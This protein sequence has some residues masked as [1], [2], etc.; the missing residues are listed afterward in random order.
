MEDDEM[1]ESRYDDLQ[2]SK[3]EKRRLR[4]EYRSLQ[5]AL[6]DNREAFLKPDNALAE[7]IEKANTLFKDVKSTQEATLDAKF[8][9]AAA[10]LSAQKASKLRLTG[11]VVEPFEVVNRV[12][13]MLGGVP[14]EDR[15]NDEEQHVPRL[16][17]NALKTA[18]AESLKRAPFGPLETEPKARKERKEIQRLKKDKSLLTKPTELKA[19][20]IEKQVNETA[21]MYKFIAKKLQQTGEINFFEFVINPDSFSQ[22]VE[23][24][25]YVAFLVKDGKA[26]III[27][28]EDGQPYIRRTALDEEEEDGGGQSTSSTSSDLSKKQVIFELTHTIWKELIETYDIREPCI[29]TRDPVHVNVDPTSSRCEFHPIQGPKIVYEVSEGGIIKTNASGPSAAAS[30]GKG[31]STSNL[32]PATLTSPQPGSV[33]FAVPQGNQTTSTSADSTDNQLDFESISEYIIPKPVLCNRLVTISTKKYKVMG[34]PVSIEDP[35]YERNA[36][37]FNLCFVFDKDANTTSYEQIVKKMARVLRSLEVESEFLCNAVTKSYILNIMEQLLQDLNTYFECQIPIN[38]ANMINLKLLPVYP[39]PEPVKDWH[40]PVALLNL[41]KATDKYWDM[42]IRRVVPFINGVFYVKKI[43]EVADVELELVRIAIQ[44]LLYFGC[45]KLVDIFK[46]EWISGVSR[47]PG[48]VPTLDSDLPP[49]TFAVVF[50]LF[51][52]FK[53]G[54]TVREWVEENNVLSLNIDIRRLIVFGIIKGFLYRVHKYPLWAPPPDYKLVA[55]EK[56]EED[57]LRRYRKYNSFSFTR[58]SNLE[59]VLAQ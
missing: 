20:D 59:L 47:P 35:K 53:H 30:P 11:N 17:W 33:T 3:E 23:N 54:H 45:I 52:S 8:L 43:A 57:K 19:N 26:S 48:G 6:E 10:D 34:Y 46:S 21:T 14:S 7:A 31:S 36:L 4:K 50:R 37:L 56:V 29:P 2:Q 22:S 55:T 27:N 28:E 5:S 58:E 44:H 39:N 13:T 41:E 49:P 15:D 16:D 25:F 40:V 9:I 32:R 24:L 1:L 38:D 51:C 12:F 42:T 18:V